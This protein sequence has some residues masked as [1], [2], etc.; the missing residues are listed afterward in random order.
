MKT[1]DTVRFLN[2]TGGGIVRRF[3]N[4]DIV[5]VE[6]PDGFETPVLIRECIVIDEQNVS[7]NNIPQKTATVALVP[8]PEER[9]QEE[10]QPVHREITETSGGDRLNIRLAYLPVDSKNLS[11]SN[12][13]AYLVN[14]SN[15]Y[16]F[17]NY[18]CRTNNAW[19]SRHSEVI[20]PNTRLFIEEFSKA[21]LSDLEKICVQL[22]AF[23]KDKPFAL[24]NPFSVEL[25]LEPLNFFKLHSFR[26]ND[27]FED[28]A[29]IYPLVTNDEPAREWWIPAADLQEA[30]MKR[31]KTDLPQPKPV[32]IKKS[33]APAIIEVD[34][35]INQLLDTTAGLSNADMLNYQLD[36]FRKT[37]EENK[38]KKGQ[39]IVFIHGKGEGVLRSAVLA[40]LKLKYK[41]C[42]VQD[43]SFREYGFGATMV[44]VL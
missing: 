35:H 31:A 32:P 43:A 41:Q 42:P 18:M 1:G 33:T 30:L 24:K 11:K 39:K 27:Y 28:D 26:E 9:I 44:T 16:L 23:K 22:L 5:V 17:F 12:Y 37:M 25:H 2:A 36:T 13:E 6:E 40:E 34:L 15:Y 38:N 21:Q 3:Q 10:K 29:L 14:D 7:A 4:K 19:M 20:E 8:V